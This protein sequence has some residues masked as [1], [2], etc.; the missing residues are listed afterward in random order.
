MNKYDFF[1][2][3][4]NENGFVKEVFAENY[5]DALGIVNAFVDKKSDDENVEYFL[6]DRKSEGTG[7]WLKWQ[8]YVS[9]GL[10]IPASFYS[11]E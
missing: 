11:N 1:V 6:W 5:S 10:D 4:E 9:L 2:I 7:A 3:D 8:T